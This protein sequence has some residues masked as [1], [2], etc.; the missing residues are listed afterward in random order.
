MVDGKSEEEH[1]VSSFSVN[2][3]ISLNIFLVQIL[4]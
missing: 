3:L 2:I 4:R 1:E